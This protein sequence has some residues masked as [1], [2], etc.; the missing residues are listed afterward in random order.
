MLYVFPT[1]SQEMPRRVDR[2]FGFHFDFHASAN[3]KEIGKYF[4][5]STLEDF[6]MRT[7]PDFI[8]IDSKGHPGYSSYPTEVGYSSG[9]FFGDPIRQWRDVTA[10]FNLPLYVHYS[11]IWDDKAI[12]TNPEWGRINADGSVDLTKASVLGG[13]PQELMVPQ[14]KEIINRYEI[15]GIWIDG[16]CWST[17]LDYSPNVVAGFLR[18]SGMTEVPRSAGEPG[19]SRW[20]DYNR[21]IFRDY[22]RDYVD[23]LHRFMPTFQVASNWAYSSMMPEPVDTDVDFLSGD[24]S[25]RNSIYSAAFQSRCLALQGKPWDL[26]AWGFVPM[27]FSGGIHSPKSAVQLKQEAAEVLAMG[28]GVQVYFQQNRDASFQTTI[29]VNAMADLAAFCRARQPFAENARTIPQVALWYSVAGWKKHNMGVYGW[30]SHLESLTSLLLDGQHVVDITMDHHLQDNLEAYPLIVIPEWDDFDDVLKKRLLDHVANGASLLVIGAKATREFEP[31]LG[32]TFE[33]PDKEEQ[34]NIGSA[35]L[36]GVTGIRTRWQRAIAQP[37]TQTVGHIYHQRDYRF[38]T[39]YVAAS[40]T[41]LGAGKIAAV[42][43]DLTAPYKGS[44]HPVYNRLINTLIQNIFPN[45]KLQVIG[46]D[47]I[48]TTLTYKDSDILVNLINADGPHVNDQVMAYDHIAPSAPLSVRLKI[49]RKPR[50]VLL[51]PENRP[52]KYGYDRESGIVTVAVPAVAIH[53]I[54]Q[55]VNEEK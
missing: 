50:R 52:L 28:G 15:D 1:Y 46:S 51:Q 29:D 23:E 27:D 38:A 19:F 31:W 30:P 43:F 9:S 10:R 4:E 41:P 14:I 34:F 20:Q 33:G 21:R 45:P 12:G 37:T 5:A 7:K 22:L 53:S 32:V 8:Q 35:A 6:L 49:N 55:F 13:Y 47:K 3:D 42:Y 18:S 44:R 17:G 11:S 39:P 24:V 16:D 26:M 40:I 54:V 2:F 25:G 48:H 36:G